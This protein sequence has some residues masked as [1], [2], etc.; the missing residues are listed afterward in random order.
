MG[1]ASIKS[2]HIEGSNVDVTDEMTN[3]IK[4]QQQF[5]GAAR[6]MQAN[7][8]MIEKLTR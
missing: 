2:G 5:N 3:M 1:F 7:S 4:A 6:M 8:D